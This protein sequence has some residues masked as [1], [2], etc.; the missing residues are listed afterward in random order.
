MLLDDL[1]KIS[2][3]TS[4]TNL[5]TGSARSMML[6]Y[7]WDTN[8]SNWLIRENFN[9]TEPIFDANGLLQV[10]LFGDGTNNKFR[11]AVRETSVQAPSNFE[12]S[13][14]YDVDWLGWKLVTWDLSLGETGSWIGNGILIRHCTLTVSR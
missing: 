3:S 11:F 4:V 14:W 13:H 1:T 8:E 7:G 5:N 9:L 6:E 10:F 12:V 2:S